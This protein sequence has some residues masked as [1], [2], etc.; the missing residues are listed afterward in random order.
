MSDTTAS[1]LLNTDRI[2]IIQHNCRKSK[3]AMSSCLKSN[4]NTAHI[5]LLQE[6]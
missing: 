3:E 4:K 5:I 2:T 1:I 6:P